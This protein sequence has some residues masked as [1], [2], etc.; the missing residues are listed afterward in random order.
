[1][2]GLPKCSAFG[3]V[4]IRGM[5]K[6]IYQIREYGH[7]VHE[8]EEY[9]GQGTSIQQTPLDGHALLCSKDKKIQSSVVSRDGLYLLLQ[10]LCEEEAFFTVIEC[11]IQFLEWNKCVI[12]P[13][14]VIVEESG[15][16]E[17]RN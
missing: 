3:L 6:G 10:N 1:M 14:A 13:S 4:V 8:S 11:L 5:P 17:G 12:T 16:F 9:N 7:P 15:K 2:F